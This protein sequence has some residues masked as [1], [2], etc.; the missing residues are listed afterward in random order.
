[1]DHMKL[2][3]D[4]VWTMAL[5]LRQMLYMGGIH[6]RQMLNFRYKTGQ[7]IRMEFMSILEQLEFPGVSVSSIHH[8]NLIH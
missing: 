8:N 3:Y 5:T 1:M 2:S 4:T 7:T 6:G